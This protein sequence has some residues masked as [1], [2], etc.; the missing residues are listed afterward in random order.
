M[1]DEF[2]K[3]INFKIFIMPV[4]IITIIFILLGFF[5]REAITDFYYKQTEIES[6]GQARS[7][8]Q[9]LS[10]AVDARELINSF[11]DE[12]LR[13]ASKTA[14]LYS[15]NH[16]NETLAELTEL[17]EIDAIY[18]YDKNGVV[19][20]SSTGDFIGWEAYEGHPVKFFMTGEINQYVEPIRPDSETGVLYKF[21]YVKAED[22]TFVQIGVLADR[23][24]SFLSGFEFDEIFDKDR[25]DKTET[26][27]HFIDNGMKITES[28]D[29]EMLG[30]TIV[31]PL[32]IS[33]I[34][35][36][37][38][39]G[40]INK[41]NGKSVYEVFVPLFADGERLGTLAVTKSMEETKGL[42]INLILI[43]LTVL[44]I[45]YGAL[46]YLMVTTHKRSKLLHE[47]AYFDE[48]TGLP[49][50]NFLKV[51]LEKKINA[52]SETNNTVI[53]VNCSNIKVI[54]ML[55]GFSYGDM[56]L[57]QF[58]KKINAFTDFD[59][60]LFRFSAGRFVIYLKNL[61]ERESLSTFADQL[62]TMLNK[63]IVIGDDEHYLQ[64]HVSIV[65]LNRRY[66]NVDHVFRNALLTLENIRN[67][68]TISYRFFDSEME[69][70]VQR[71]E[72]IE[73]DLRN[74]L[75]S[76]SN[77]KIYAAYQPQVC[78]K[79]GEILGFEALARL[80]SERLG[81]VSPNEFIEIA[82]KKHLIVPLGNFILRSACEFANIIQSKSGRNIKMSV[83]VSAI[84]LLCEDFIETVI[85]IVEDTGIPPY[86]LELEITE[87]VILENFELI[88]NKLKQLKSHGIEIA[89]DDFG[90][91]YSSFMR[92]N[93][94]NIDTV[95]I[96][97]YFINKI[98][99]GKKG[100]NIVGAIIAMAQNKG[101]VV[102][103]EGVEDT[104][105]KQYLIDQNCDIM[106]GFLFSRPV[107]KEQA[108]EMIENFE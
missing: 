76:E 81:N 43:G 85:K 17:L 45:V 47:L 103:A 100:E 30:K 65:E 87:S 74:A 50:K 66:D 94:L 23:L 36:G 26:Y 8:S 33:A 93:E 107:S 21:A 86:L 104:G 97:R 52:D 10:K 41:D 13:V 38:D 11:L 61:G 105:Q 62:V 49:N 71:Q 40:T 60:P 102:V 78:L 68:D 84:Q 56:V 7:Y 91:G 51:F 106:Q 46:M 55:Y 53:F 108:L 77:N 34:S 57:E 19:I 99:N 4:S 64:T 20:H 75:S 31:D 73:K 24:Y 25:L 89:L 54:N 3:K 101:L 90:T 80:E 22:G 42:I 95:K 37:R 15:G 96:D 44:A 98:T 16:S 70:K 82:E 27:I 29:T 2:N 32:I 58:G 9:N 59:V 6:L 39:Y 18:S 35:E 48:L 63:P 1:G 72:I 12:K 92:F 83:N 28:T 69:D 67:N 14:G 88:N 5:V 79:T